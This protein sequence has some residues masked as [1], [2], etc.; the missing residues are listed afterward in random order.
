MDKS[1]NVTLNGHAEPYRLT[2]DAS[3][4]LSRYL[5]RAASR[6]RDDADRAE[7]LGDLERSVGDKL[8]ALLRSGDR[9][10]TA[11]DID[12]VLEQ[13]GA[14][15][16]GHDPVA[17]EDTAPPKRRL[18][19]IREGQKYAGVCNGLAAYADLGVEPVRT[20]FI[21]ATVFT[22]GIFGLVY[23]ALAFLL[24]VDATRSL[25]NSQRP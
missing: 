19:R 15:D 23:V 16:T 5:D 9:L 18:R 6:L 14:V 17:D 22:G 8:A 10:I 11:A 7:V 24:P 1:I 12:G 25:Q 21:L 3:D 4:R 20:G 13:I 2:E